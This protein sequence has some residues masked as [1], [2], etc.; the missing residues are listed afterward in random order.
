MPDDERGVRG[1]TREQQAYSLPGIASATCFR[2]MYDTIDSHT[3]ALEWLEST[4]QDI[5]YQPTAHIYALLKTV[6]KQT[7]TACDFL[8]RQKYVNTGIVPN[9]ISK[10]CHLLISLDF[11]P[12]NILLS[13]LNTSHVISK[14]ADLGLGKPACKRDRRFH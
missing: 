10:R 9:L 7:L 8:A 13:G 4:M 5:K 6:L 2:E 11:K 14:V 1:I 12:A 3:I